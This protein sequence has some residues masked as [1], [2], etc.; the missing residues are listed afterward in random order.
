M[1]RRQNAK[2][3]IAG[4]KG[5]YTNLQSPDSPGF[6][7]F[8]SPG[9]GSTITDNDLKT[10]VGYVSG[11]NKKRTDVDKT[12]TCLDEINK[13]NTNVN[14]VITSDA[15]EDRL[16]Y[17][18]ECGL[19]AVQDSN[20]DEIYCPNGYSSVGFVYEYNSASSNNNY[21]ICK[22]D[23]PASD[24]DCCYDKD[25]STDINKC[26]DGFMY[27]T[28]D[29]NIR[30]RKHCDGTDNNIKDSKYCKTWCNDGNN[31]DINGCVDGYIKF[32]EKPENRTTDFCMGICRKAADTSRD[33]TSG[34]KN[35]ELR[36]MCEKS[37]I[38]FCKKDLKKSFDNNTDQ[39]KFCRSFCINTNNPDIKAECDTMITNY[40]VTTGSDS[41]FC[42]CIKPT[43]GYSRYSSQLSVHCMDGNCMTYGYKTD[44]MNKFKC[45]ECI[46][47]ATIMDNINS[48]INSNQTMVCNDKGV[49]EAVPKKPESPQT[50]TTP[51]KPESPQR[52]TTPSTNSTNEQNNTNQTGN[53]NTSTNLNNTGTKNTST[54]IDKY[55]SS[56]G[57]IPPNSSTSNYIEKNFWDL[58]Q[59]DNNILVPVLLFLFFF[60]VII[61]LN[62]FGQNNKRPI[63]RMMPMYRNNPYY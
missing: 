35:K 28:S 43:T 15:F 17:N 4:E 12:T 56:Q 29:C 39:S 32:C 23:A 34:S 45:P 24:L 21:K 44:I 58:S 61:V 18:T 59:I 10:K 9:C 20:R 13:G 38:S 46:Q 41:N 60:I 57:N 51:K 14:C 11:P 26:K 31:N 3:V 53:N 5:T 8:G 36:T 30:M 27:G 25:Q 7:L 37:M 55:T 19:N 33:K 6:S 47:V 62:I 50:P 48:Q 40:C 2:F 1:S 42:S 54:T 49:P 22:R 63:R 16:Y 52:P